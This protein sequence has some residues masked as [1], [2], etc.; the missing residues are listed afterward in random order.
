MATNLLQQAARSRDSVFQERV[1]AAVSRF[2]PDVIGEAVNVRGHAKR[3]EYMKRVIAPG[4]FQLYVP[5]ITWAIAGDSVILG[6]D[7]TT[8][9]T[10][11][12]LTGAL[13]RV[14]NALAGVE[15]SDP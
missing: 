4:G 13:G 3:A 6:V 15:A 11:V 12:Q 10:D 8:A 9:I 14:Y 1:Q 5:V 7:D 2:I